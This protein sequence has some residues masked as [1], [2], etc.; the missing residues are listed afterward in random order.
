MDR[1]E[2]L[3]QISMKSRPT[4]KSKSGIFASKFFWIGVVGVAVLILIM[5]IGGILSGARGSN[6][7][8]LFALILHIDNTSEVIG[9]Y[10]P[11]VKSS[12]LRSDSSS[13]SV[14]L[15]DTSKD[16][17]NYATE[18][19]N[20]K[21]KDVSKSITEEETLAKDGLMNELF[22]AKINGNLDRVYAHKM[23]YEIS[24][25]ATREKQLL[26]STS[27]EILKNALNK[28]YSSLDVLYNKF[29]ESSETK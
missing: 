11:S 20:F 19:Y 9:K 26:K 22:E 15:S 7:D 25:I 17:T 24:L 29:D 10:Q 27:N 23:A 16:L 1:Q 4:K 5:I 12:N 14:I 21:V 3:N 13:L 6:K 8:R 28:S 18:K 2:Y